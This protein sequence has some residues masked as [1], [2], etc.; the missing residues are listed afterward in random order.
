M[1]NFK[2][3]GDVITLT[4]P[5]GGVVSGNAYKIGQLLVVAAVSALAGEEFEG[6]TTG[7]FILPKDTADVMTEG[8]PVYWDSANSRLTI[9]AL[10]G[11]LVGAAVKPALAA[12]TTGE[13]RLDGVVRL[14][15]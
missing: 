8:V 7:V 5:A 11:L 14:Q 13:F 3:P 2:Q 9:V 15:S 10:G 1:Q 6:K 12:D 4:A